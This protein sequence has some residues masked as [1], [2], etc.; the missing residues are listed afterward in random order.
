MP[1]RRLAD[2]QRAVAARLAAA[3]V[4][5]ANLDARVL[6]QRLLDLDPGT[7]IANPDRPVSDAEH[8][9]LATAVA[10]RVAR[11]PLAYIV[12]DREFWSL[13]FAVAPGV[14]IPRPDSET[15]VEAALAALAPSTPARVLDL[16]TG[17]GCLLLAVLSE[18]PVATG[19][20]V[21]VDERAARLARANADR[22]GLARRA[23]FIVA[24]WA[25]AV[26]GPFDLVLC[27]PP[28]VPAADIAGLMPEV[29]RHEPRL[30][31]DGGARG[32]DAYA[33]LLPQLRRILAPAG[34][35]VLEIG[36]AQATDVAALAQRQGLLAAPP[37]RD[38][39]GHDRCLVVTRPSP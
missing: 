27:N 28:Y 32:L 20:G 31:L 18:R 38:L 12:G 1:D 5:T 6:L 15:V 9:R 19:V 37:R 23:H 7:M 25:T 21:D 14:L 24:D 8:D 35:A 34:A 33:V 16:G 4:D 36:A 10:R 3:G 2:V 39:A 13:D 26:A 29:A 22:L 30:A 11:E 17:T